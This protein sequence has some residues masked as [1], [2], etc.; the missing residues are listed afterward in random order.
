LGYVNE[1]PTRCTHKSVLDC[2]SNES[3]SSDALA[4]RKLR[5]T[6]WHTAET[7]ISGEAPRRRHRSLTFA[8]SH[9][10]LSASVMTS[11]SLMHCRQL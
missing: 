9:A 11:L 7:T 6:F 2:T 3:C 4:C 8:E 1:V 10:K 5:W